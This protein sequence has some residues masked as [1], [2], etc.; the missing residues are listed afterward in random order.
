MRDADPRPSEASH[1]SEIYTGIREGSGLDLSDEACLRGL[2]AWSGLIG[3]ISLE[4]FGHLYRGVSDY[5]AH[6]E[7]ILARLDP[8]GP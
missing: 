6:F 8:T 5:A 2:E 1:P 7:L 4:L 3:A